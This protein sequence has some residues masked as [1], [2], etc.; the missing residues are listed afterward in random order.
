MF[1]TTTN[2]LTHTTKTHTQTQPAPIPLVAQPGS[3]RRPAGTWGMEGKKLV[4]Y[5]DKGVYFDQYEVRVPGFPFLRP[6][7]CAPLLGT[8]LF[9]AFTNFSHAPT[10]PLS[11]TL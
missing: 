3:R 7:S 1:T 6:I 10:K 5:S 2:P 8:L 11:P 4:S 9:L